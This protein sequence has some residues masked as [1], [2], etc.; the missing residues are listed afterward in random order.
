ML[1]NICIKLSKILSDY[2]EY[3]FT[4]KNIE[5]LARILNAYDNQIIPLEV[6]KRNLHLD[7]KQVNDLLL[8]LARNSITQL[9]YK[10]WCENPNCNAD[11]E[12]YENIYDIPLDEC[13]YCD[14]R[15]KKM[16]NVYIV[17]RVNLNE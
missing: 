14:K 11:T 13:D 6:I 7:Y 2:K 5:L 10:I 9:N 3:N 15:C 1:S 17:Y 4:E 16:S 8:Y 12:V